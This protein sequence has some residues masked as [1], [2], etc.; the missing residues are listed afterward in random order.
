MTKRFI[1]VGVIFG[2]LIG[3][4]AFFH[5]VF[6]PSMIKQAILGSPKP[7]E[8]ISADAA[9]VER[10]A[11]YV[12]AIGTVQAVNGI[13]VA[14]KVAGIVK[15][16]HFESG[17]DVAKG[18]T[19]VQLDDAAEQADLRNLEATAKSAQLELARQQTLAQRGV[20]ARKDLEAAQ[21][22]SD[23]L[24]AQIDRVKSTIADKTIVAPWAGR[25]GIRH[26]DVGAYVQPGQ[27]L[28]WLQTLDPVYVD[29]T[30]PETEFDRIRTDQTI[31][32]TFST[33]PGEVFAGK[34]TA[35]EAKV[36]ESTRTINVRAT[37]P[38]SEHKIAAGMFASVAVIIDAPQPVV[39]V[40]ETAITYSLYGDSV[41]VVVPAKAEPAAQGATKPAANAAA[42]AAPA[43]E[44]PMQVERRFVKI[45]EVREGRS[46]ILDGLKEGEKVVNA[47][48]LKLR[49]GSLVKID[50]SVALGKPEETKIE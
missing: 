28:V 7:A 3:G 24:R 30:V 4:L 8:T 42:P 46:S 17:A 32:T 19:L 34:I 44:P 47:G 16:F 43:T 36:D 13:E 35:L 23:A 45:G 29:F 38:N 9:T 11:P 6:L 12:R 37:L 27:A 21:A 10:W 48:Q 15:E 22:S 50:N 49:P 31:E 33:Y 1:I 14:P 25:V 41:F 39:T 5:F 40:P 26:A 2:L 20:S 18:D